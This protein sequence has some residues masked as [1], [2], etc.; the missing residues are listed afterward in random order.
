MQG[1]I[2]D[3]YAPS[4]QLLRFP[5]A[6]ST[7]ADHIYRDSVIGY[8]TGTTT[9]I[10]GM[11]I[12]FRVIS[13]HTPLEIDAYVADAFGNI[14]TIPDAYAI[15]YPY[16]TF[17]LD[18]VDVSRLMVA[19]STRIHFDFNTSFLLHQDQTVYF[20]F[21]SI[22]DNAFL[23]N[24]VGGSYVD[25]YNYCCSVWAQ[26]S[27]GDRWTSK[28]WNND[29]RTLET[30]SPNARYMPYVELYADRTTCDPLI[31]SCVPGGGGTGT[32]STSTIDLGAGFEYGVCDLMSPFQCIKNAFIWAVLPPPGAFD[33]FI[34]LKDQLAVHAP[35]GY[36]T[37][38]I[39]LVQLDS[40][41]TADLI[42]VASGNPLREYIFTPIRDTL[43]VVM[44]IFAI[45][46][47]IRRVKDIQI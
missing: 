45:V 26:N 29:T 8:T 11:A 40:T 24:S 13:E 47:F 23:F 12:D 1:T 22:T 34:A 19:S 36:F 39:Q 38:A 10:S 28:N 30:G 25:R 16:Q 15:V 41:T 21:Y 32:T 3:M 20:R 33:D 44:Y 46:W 35:F 31:Q 43:V 6:S 18:F 7:C 42:L 14:Q 2:G 17:T 27:I 37:S 4:A 9:M 5:L